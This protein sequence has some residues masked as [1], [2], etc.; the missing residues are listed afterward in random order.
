[1]AIEY[2]LTGLVVGSV[3]V[4]LAV[5]VTLIWGVL[6]VLQFAHGAVYMLGAYLAFTFVRVSP[7]HYFVALGVSIVATAG[8]GLLI[9]WFIF[10]PL[11]GK[12]RFLQPVAALGLSALLTDAARLIWTPDP[13][14]MRTL[15][16]TRVAQLGP[17]TISHQRIMVV[18]C[19]ALLMLLLYALV[20]KTKLGKAM[21][22]V[23]MDPEVAGYMGVNVSAVRS[24]T[25]SI[26]CGMAAAAGGILA[27]VYGLNPHMGGLVGLKA[28]VVVVLGGLGNVAG[29]TVAGLLLGVTESLAVAFLS[30]LWKDVVAFLVLIAIL[31]TR[32]HGIF[33]TE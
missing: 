10:R 24:I 25:F 2:L 33:R 29:A 30:T 12:P 18:A 1:M 13:R 27:P 7:Q 15:Y 17:L 19:A 31:V 4:L 14:S 23:S 6:G 20:N 11:R 28:F 16:V 32:P 21:R 8:V 26:A 3:Y 22:A 5:G 9:E